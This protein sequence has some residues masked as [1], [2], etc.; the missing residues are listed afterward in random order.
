M[1]YLHCI[2]GI[3][4]RGAQTFGCIWV[5]LVMSTLREVADLAFPTLHLVPASWVGA[6]PPVVPRHLVPPQPPPCGCRREL[7][8]WLLIR[9]FI[10]PQVI[11]FRLCNKAA[12]PCRGR[13]LL[14]VGFGFVST[15]VLATR[16]ST[17]STLAGARPVDLLFSFSKRKKYLESDIV[18][19]AA[20]LVP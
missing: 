3:Y 9:L 13:S 1:Q 17:S 16:G 10:V 18:R 19:A 20:I 12:P 4:R 5:R 6:S 8:C 15:Y 14:D 2:C 7:R 11:T